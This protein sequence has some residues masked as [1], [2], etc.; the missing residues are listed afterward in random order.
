MNSYE[1]ITETAI[2]SGFTFV[3]QSSYNLC[4]S[5]HGLT[6]ISHVETFVHES[7]NSAFT[8]FV[9]KELHLVSAVS[10]SL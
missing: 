7:V 1:A 4:S 10:W 2:F 3:R 9:I 8:F 5:L 6:L